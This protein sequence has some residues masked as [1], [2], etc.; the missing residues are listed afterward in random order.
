L[1]YPAELTFSQ[2]ASRYLRFDTGLKFRKNNRRYSWILSL[3]VQ[4]ITNR[5]NVLEVEPKIAPGNSIHLSATVTDPGII[6]V[7]NL[8]IEF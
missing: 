4:D 2:H 3:D 5:Q 6:P 7:L 8:K 1:Y